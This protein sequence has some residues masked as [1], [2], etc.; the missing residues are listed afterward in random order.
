MAGKNA[1]RTGVVDIDLG[2]LVNE[3]LKVCIVVL[4]EG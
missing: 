4:T 2:R 3:L 1:R